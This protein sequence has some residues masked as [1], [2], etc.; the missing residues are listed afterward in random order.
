MAVTTRSTTTALGIKLPA[1][2][3]TIFSPFIESPIHPSP[4]PP[5]LFLQTA[6]C[7]GK[8][9]N[10]SLGPLLRLFPT[11][12]CNLPHIVSCLP[13]SRLPFTA[14]VTPSTKL[15]ISG[16]FSFFLF[17]HRVECYLQEWKIQSLMR[18]VYI[19]AFNLKWAAG[20][21]L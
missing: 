19:R 5:R 8:I 7:S 10:A 3:A 18:R 12:K 2:A 4:F 20:L 17:S 15:Y 6:R 21:L 11:Q 16:L 14:G 9:K 1:E 13:P